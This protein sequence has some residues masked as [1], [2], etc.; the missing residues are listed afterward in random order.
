LVVSRAGGAQQHMIGLL[1]SRSSD[2][3]AN[4]LAGFCQGLTEVGFVDAENVRV[5]CRWADNRAD[6]LPEMAADLVRQQPDVIFASGGPLPAL[7]AKAATKTIPI[8]FLVGQDPTNLGLVSSLAR[9]SGNLTGLNLFANGLEAK[10]LQLLHQ[11]V[12]RAARI[13]VLTNPADTAYTEITLQEVGAAA[14]ALGL[15]LKNFAATTV[16]E[17]DEAFSAMG[18]EPP[19]A[20]FVAAAPFLNA[21]RVQL[22]HLAVL[23][24]LPATGRLRDFAEAGG[25]MAYGPSIVDA[26]RQ[27]GVYVGHILKGAKP[28]DL[29]VRQASKFELFI[30]LSTA[31]LLG[32]SPPPTLLAMADEVLE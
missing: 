32:I 12:P 27:C 7:A 8:V 6:R 20:L 9:P 28:A 26:F 21:R 22:I 5:V 14:R 1:E 30:N 24:R 2:G 19:D 15:Q 13:A 18:Q 10:R 3:M 16:R 4:R 25:L 23:H 31:R 29:P 17:I 11:L